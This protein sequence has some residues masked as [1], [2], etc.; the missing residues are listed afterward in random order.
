M[1]YVV[2]AWRIF[3][4]KLI[5]IGE[6]HLTK[7]PLVTKGSGHSIHQEKPDMVALELSDLLDKLYY[8]LDLP[9]SKL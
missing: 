8:L 9:A 3:L 2:P 1:A 4:S 5:S 7:G 6:P